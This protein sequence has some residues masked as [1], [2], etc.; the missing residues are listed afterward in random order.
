M[1]FENYNLKSRQLQSH[2]IISYDSQNLQVLFDT[3][4]MVILV[5]WDLKILLI[6]F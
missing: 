6:V 2:Y 1:Q 3:R 4:H 5:I